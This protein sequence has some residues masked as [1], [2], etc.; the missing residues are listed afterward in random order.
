M[1]PLL[2]TSNS[3]IYLRRILA[4]LVAFC[5]FYGAATITADALG[6]RYVYRNGTQTVTQHQ[7][8]DFYA[9]EPHSL[10]LLVL[11]SSHAM[12]S[13]DPMRIEKEFGLSSFNLGTAL[14]SPDTAYYLLCEVLKTQKP[15]YLI[16]DVYFKV[17]ESEY[18]DEQALTVLKE[19]KPSTTAISLFWN[20]LTRNAKVSFYNTWVNPFS[21]IE[22]FM[23]YHTPVSENRVD[24]YLGRGFYSSPGVVTHDLLSEET[25]PFP[26]TFQGFNSRQLE[27]L[28]KLITLAQKNGIEVILTC[29]P[30]PPTIL[31][32]VGYYDEIL[33]CTQ[34]IAN[35]F[36]IAFYDFAEPCMQ[37]LH[38]YDFAD[39]GHLNR[40]GNRKFM[41]FF[42][43]SGILGGVSNG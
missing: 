30:L 16:Y 26:D 34:A 13:Y 37:I 40:D 8:Q 20:N 32:R 7:L 43:E 11:G 2:S 21:R 17:L 10:D 25:H 1:K 27:Y 31:S 39:Q 41:D 4:F 35:E 28:K 6:E 24:S 12:C 14:Q 9:L 3:N 29:A 42:V 38:D 18:G 23:Q 15:K 33:D 5:A 36:D 19:L 22:S